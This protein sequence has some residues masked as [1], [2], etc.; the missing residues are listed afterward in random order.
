MANTELLREK[1]ESSG[2]T[3]TALAKK[4]GFSRGTLYNKLDSGDFKVSEMLSISNSLHLSM[5]E[6][7]DIFLNSESE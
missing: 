5:K 1:I 3:M 7:D 2:I 6:R 4:C